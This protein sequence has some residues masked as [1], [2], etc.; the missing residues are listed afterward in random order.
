[1]NAQKRH[2]YPRDQPNDQSRHQSRSQ[3]ERD[4]P[5]HDVSRTLGPN[6]PGEYGRHDERGKVRGRD[7]RKIQPSAHQRDHHGERQDP[8]F[9]H[10]EGHRSQRVSRERNRSGASAPKPITANTMKR[11]EHRDRWDLLRAAR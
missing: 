5:R 2:D 8:E 9:G 7:Y 3:G 6:H 11:A 1:M 4:R 10:L